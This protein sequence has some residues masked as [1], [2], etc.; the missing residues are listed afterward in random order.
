LIINLP[1]NNNNRSFKI[2][3]HYD[4]PAVVEEN[5][6]L[7][8]LLVQNKLEDHEG[9]LSNVEAHIIIRAIKNNCPLKGLLATLYSS[10]A[11]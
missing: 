8:L 3:E 11:N 1:K 9:T 2:K 5:C 7:Q 6:P 4:T 10:R